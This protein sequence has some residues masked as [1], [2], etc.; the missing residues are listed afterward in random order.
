[1]DG[2]RAAI[3]EQPGFEVVEECHRILTAKYPM[4][5]RL[6]GSLEHLKK[7]VFVEHMIDKPHGP[8]SK[9]QVSFLQKS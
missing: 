8:I 3:S 4:W 7:K 1:M 5:K 2:G 6:E 9:I